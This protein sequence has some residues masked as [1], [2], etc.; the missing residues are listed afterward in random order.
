VAAEAPAGG[1]TTPGQPAPGATGAPGVP[2][3]PVAPAALSSLRQ[4]SLLDAR[5]AADAAALSKAYKSNKSGADLAPIMRSLAS[6]ASIGGELMPQLRTWDQAHS[7]ANARSAF[8]TSISA[9]A[10]DGLRASITDKRSYRATSR[11]LLSALKKLHTLDAASRELA[12]VANLELPEVDLS[13]LP[14]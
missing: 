11:K 8:Y 14:S 10:I 2:A 1:T 12:L 3:L 4:A 9:I 6:N 13:R 5:M 7:L